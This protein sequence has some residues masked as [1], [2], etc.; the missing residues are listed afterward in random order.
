MKKVFTDN[1]DKLLACF[2]FLVI[3]STAVGVDRDWINGLGRDAFMI[4]AGLL[5]GAGWRALSQ[6][7]PSANIEGDAVINT[8]ENNLDSAKP[9]IEGMEL[10]E[11]KEKE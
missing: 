8:S 4:L 2:V 3:F 10:I 7:S 5:G 6:R 1:F 11:I 9:E